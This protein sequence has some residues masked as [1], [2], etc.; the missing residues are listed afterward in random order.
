MRMKD[1]KMIKILMRAVTVTEVKVMMII[2]IRFFLS[3]A[4]AK[5]TFFLLLTTPFSQG[6]KF[7]SHMSRFL[8]NHSSSFLF[9]TVPPPLCPVC[10]CVCVCVCFIQMMYIIF[11][12]KGHRVG[13]VKL[14]HYSVILL[15]MITDID[16]NI[17]GWLRYRWRV[18]WN[19]TR[20]ST[21]QRS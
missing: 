8:F 1:V 9:F 13:A 14:Y 10:A 7:H 16:D 6:M 19:T 18:C 20:T 11:I 3:K 21:C 5:T 2:V 12:V 4:V 15:E 17:S